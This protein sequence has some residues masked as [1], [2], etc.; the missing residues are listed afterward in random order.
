MEQL[1]NVYLN[2]NIYISKTVSMVFLL[3]DELT[4]TFHND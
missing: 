3:F 2:I 4:D 1:K